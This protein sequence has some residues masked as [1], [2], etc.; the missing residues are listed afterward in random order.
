MHRTFGSIAG[1]IRITRLKTTVPT[2]RDHII[3]TVGKNGPKANKAADG[4]M[5]PQS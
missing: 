4:C 1:A 5:Y 3:E 2:D